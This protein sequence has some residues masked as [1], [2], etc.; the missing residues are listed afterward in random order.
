[1][2]HAESATNLA[3]LY[4]SGFD[5]TPQNITKAILLL[6]RAASKNL[7]AKLRLA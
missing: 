1:M 2:G 3:S 5:S 7:N 6:R 4:I